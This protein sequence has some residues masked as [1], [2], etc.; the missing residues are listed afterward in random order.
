MKRKRKRREQ[1]EENRSFCCNTTAESDNSLHRHIILSNFWQELTKR[2]MRLLSQTMWSYLSPLSVAGKSETA[3]AKPNITNSAANETEKCN[4]EEFKSNIENVEN[5]IRDEGEDCKESSAIEELSDEQAPVR[6]MND[7]V[8]KR[9][10]PA[11]F[12]W[13]IL[14]TI[15]LTTAF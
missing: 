15:L 2:K 6:S 10:T 12:W 7:R 5:E 14:T 3:S 4:Y 1:E 11:S 9:D 13:V 8:S